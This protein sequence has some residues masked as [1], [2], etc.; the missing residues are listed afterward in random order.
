MTYNE[1]DPKSI[2]KHGK[3]L[4]GKSLRDLHPDK[5]NVTLNKNNKGEFGQLIEKIHFGYEINSRKEADFVEANV[6][7]KSCPL[8]NIRKIPKSHLS[9]K[10]EGL[11]VK[12]RNVLSIID[13]EDLAN[14][15]WENNKLFKKVKNLLLAFFVYEKGISRFD[16]KFRLVNLWTPSEKD[17]KIIK[18][19]WEIIQKKVLEGKAHELSEGDTMYLGAATKGASAKST[20]VQPFSKI[21]AKQRAFSYKRSY[22]DIIFEELLLNRKKYKSISEEN[23]D[24]FEDTLNRLFSPYYGKA[25]LE[26]EEVKK[27]NIELKTIRVDINNKI[28][29][30][31]SF[32]KF[33]FIELSNETWE[34]SNL[35]SYLEETKFLFVIFSTK[36]TNDE[37]KKMS[38][39]EKK[40]NIFLKGFKLWNMPTLDIE[41]EVKKMWKKTVEI[42]K[43]G[44]VIE[45]KHGNIYNNFPTKTEN[46]CMHVRPHGQNRQDTLPLPKRSIIKMKNPEKFA[47]E[48]FDFLRENKFTKQCFWLNKEYIE[49][50]IK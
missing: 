44:P 7:V 1:K 25:P 26:I 40:K 4:E 45:L 5:A 8:K 21:P 10:K 20:R 46:K 29:E 15:T 2:E 42:V 36:C 28:P 16:L 9:R 35:K 39:E 50:I 49:K 41:N 19:D 27:A 17:M 34:E 13:Y 6:E 11:S 24:T 38:K 31:I 3:L 30:N 12:E 14:Q 43:E 48:K 23:D 22:M 37:F 33:D 47:S 18:N 32:P